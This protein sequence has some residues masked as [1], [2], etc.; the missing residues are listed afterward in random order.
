MELF[1]LAVH[2]F[3]LVLHARDLGLARLDLPLELFDLVVEHELE[4][5]QLLRIQGVGAVRGAETR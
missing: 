2:L 5:L 1:E 3:D 4:L